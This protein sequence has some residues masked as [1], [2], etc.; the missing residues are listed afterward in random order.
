MKILIIGAKGF[1][2][3]HLCSY[4]TQ[5]GDEVY[6]CDIYPDTS[7][8][9]YFCVDSKNP[10]YESI[11][12]QHHFDVCI[13]AAG[14]ASVGA[15]LENPQNDYLL[16]VTNVE[17]IL[18]AIVKYNPGCKFINFSSAAVYGNP[19]SLPI[20]ETHLLSPIS[21]YGK[22]KKESEEMLARYHAEFGIST[23]SLRVFSAFGPGLRKQ[24]FWDI[25][26]KIKNAKDGSIYLYGTG[27]ETRDFIFVSDI[28]SATECLIH[29][30]GFK[31]EAINV[32]SGKETTIH[33]A[34]SLFITYYSTH[35]LLNFSG[36]TR[37]GDPNNWVSDISLLKQHGFIPAV[38]LATGI[39]KYAE[40]LK[41]NE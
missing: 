40:W 17:K 6:S 18:K 23:L 10:D 26:T 5:H 28:V 9:S 30:A 7:T 2:G 33:Q 29:K 31:G 14:A 22:H 37:E 21:P 15:S 25:Y 19:Q 34:A 3:S 38:S 8:K 12:K 20:S 35:I 41:E 11:F 13:N 16:N 1:L 24:I 32:A 27:Y 39:K 4:Y 36:T